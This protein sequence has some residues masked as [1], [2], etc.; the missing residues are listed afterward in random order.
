MTMK[1]RTLQE[2][3]QKIASGE[4][5]VLTA[6]EVSDLVSKGEEPEFN[7]VDVVTTGTCGIMSCTAAIF[8]I[9][10]G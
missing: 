10:V 3:K 6:E 1:S 9:K 4:A 5:A 7:D 8:H 2:I